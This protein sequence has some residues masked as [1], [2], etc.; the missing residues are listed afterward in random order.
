MNDVD[1]SKYRVS[2]Q[3][4]QGNQPI[5]QAG[6]QDPIQRQNESSD[7]SKYRSKE[8]ESIGASAQR[9]ITRQAS[10]AAETFLGMPG[11]LLRMGGHGAISGAEALTG[12][13]FSGA[14]QA[15]EDTAP[16][17]LLP[18]SQQLRGVQ[19]EL[20]GGY[21]EPNPGTWEEN[22][23]NVTKTL[24]SLKT[25]GG[26]WLRS[27]GAAIGGEGAGKIAKEYG[28]GETGQNIANIG[29][30]FLL[31]NLNPGQAE[32]FVQKSYEK[33]RAAI[34]KGTMLQT[35]SYVSALDSLEQTL[36]R[37]APTATKDAVLKSLRYMRD[38]AKGGAM[39][40]SEVV[41][42]YHD[43]NQSMNSK[44]LFDELSA[45]EK[46]T[47]KR[48]YESLKDQV[49]PTIEGYG[50]Y[51]P[52][53]IENW[54]AG[55][56]GYAAIKKSERTRDW[57]GSKIKHLPSKLFGGAA[58]ELLAGYPQLA[59]ATAGGAIAA[60]TGLRTIETANRF[61]KSPI[62]RKHYLQAIKSASASNLPAMIRAMEMM[63]EADK[64]EMKKESLKK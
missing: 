13:D 22:A 31:H 43:V 33:A 25:G 2:E 9:N 45:S 4:S 48:Q 15:L 39:E 1:L 5:K 14:K 21:T 64:R 60:G 26:G 3:S 17:K 42:A 58:V 46:K 19:K 10:R 54:N 7:L 49:R 50:Q 52:E 12:K 30:M 11:D 37:G 59:V 40:A 53:F 61:L 36:M 62:L 27:L 51:N 47:L 56:A 29:T 24:T 8:P 44:G 55:N 23:D 57:V 6:K 32:N 28:A 16:F 41:D 63:D 18:S 38:R 35:G 20:T 34:P